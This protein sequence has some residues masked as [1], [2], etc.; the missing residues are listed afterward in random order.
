MYIHTY[1][2]IHIIY[3]GET[4]LMRKEAEGVL[5]R[6]YRNMVRRMCW[7]KVRDRKSSLEIMS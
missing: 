5:Q 7:V 6:A 1:T 2:Y 3:G 4:W